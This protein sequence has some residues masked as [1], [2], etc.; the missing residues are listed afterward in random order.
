METYVF[1]ML[2]NLS[3]LL[4][5]SFTKFVWVCNTAKLVSYYQFYN[6]QQIKIIS[7]E[8]IYRAIYSR[9]N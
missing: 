6:Q 2:I 5:M 8:I 7:E 1:L 9:G 4:S 3:R